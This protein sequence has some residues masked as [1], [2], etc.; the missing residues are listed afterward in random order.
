[1]QPGGAV[2]AGTIS[3]VEGNAVYV[4]GPDGKETRI[5]LDAQTRIQ[6]QV[7]GTAADLKTGAQV[8]VQAQGQPGSDGT[9]T[10]GTVSLLPEGANTALREQRR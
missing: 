2:T 9:V 8:A 4:T 1:M 10:A 3:R 5:A 6:K 7:D